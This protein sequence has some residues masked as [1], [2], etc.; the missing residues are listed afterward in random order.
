M[1]GGLVFKNTLWLTL[2]AMGGRA[3]SYGTFILLARCFTER[4]VGVW[5][6]LLTAYL[7]SEIISNLGL[8]KIVIRD[9]AQRPEEG[10]RLLAAALAV[11]LLV[12]IPT[13]AAAL[14]AVYWGYPEIASAY[15]AAII[16]FFLAVPAIAVTRSLEAWHTAR[17]T[18]AI[19]ALAQVTERIVLLGL[20]SIFWLAGLPFGFFIGASAI[21]P[22]ARLAVV[23][24]PAWIHLRKPRLDLARPLISESLVLFA[25]EAVAGLYLRVD[26]ILVSKLGSLE[27]AGLYNAAYRVFE[28]FTVVFS[29]YLLAIFP[30]LARR[31]RFSNFKSTFQLGLLVVVVAALIGFW[32]RHFILGLFGPAYLAASSAFSLLMLALPLSYMT[33]FFSNYLVASGQTRILLICAPV[34][35]AANVAMNFFFI[36]KIAI[37]G[38]GLAFVL[39][40]LTSCLLLLILCKIGPARGVA[41]PQP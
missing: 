17:E 12:S 4:E 29:G 35:V 15:P 26:L 9:V 7:F 38:A 19:P 11:K 10:E 33:S 40:E 20:L 30:A 18:M 24:K 25:V 14:A 8:D 41:R 6:V 5:A 16:L 3:V 2:A 28:F 23:L 36:P 13:G 1:K 32:L 39:S 34:V 37:A 22:L 21:A 27:E 31:A